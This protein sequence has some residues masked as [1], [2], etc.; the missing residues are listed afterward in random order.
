[1]AWYLSSAPP[2]STGALTHFL[3]VQYLR[4]HRHPYVDAVPRAPARLL[5]AGSHMRSTRPGFNIVGAWT[6]PQ[7]AVPWCAASPAPKNLDACGSGGAAR[8]TS[9]HEPNSLLPPSPHLCLWL[10]CQCPVGVVGRKVSIILR[11][12][13]FQGPRA[14][15][16]QGLNDFNGYQRSTGFRVSRDSGFPLL[17]RVFKGVASP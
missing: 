7:C 17:S 3:A 13:G 16:S 9:H 15:R 14:N 8:R 2:P 12:S 6:R 5:G 4:Y 1:M 10:W 11:V